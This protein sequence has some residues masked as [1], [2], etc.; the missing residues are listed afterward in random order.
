MRL[1]GQQAQYAQGGGL[2]KQK[3]DIHHRFTLESYI[4]LV[5]K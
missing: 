4:R 2:R 5:A 3:H 1:K